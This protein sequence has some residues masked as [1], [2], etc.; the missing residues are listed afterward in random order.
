MPKKYRS[1]TWSIVF[2]L[3]ALIWAL[4]FLATI[5]GADHLKALYRARASAVLTDRNGEIVDIRLNSAGNYALRL[6]RLPAATAR[7]IIRKEDRWFYYH[8]GINPLSLV[9]AAWRLV[10]GGGYPSSSTITQQTA[11]LLLGQERERSIGNKLKEAWYAL[12]LEAHAGKDSILVMYANTAFFGNQAEGL[13]TAARLYCGRDL[14]ELTGAQ[15]VRL[16]AALGN[17]AGDNPFRENNIARSEAL[18]RRLG[19]ATD[20]GEYPAISEEAAVNDFTAYRQNEAAFEMGDLRSASPGGSRLTIDSGLT[21][22]IRQIAGDSLANMY[23]SGARNAAVAVIATPRGK[24]GNELLALV[25]SPD[26]SVDARG[27]KINMALRPRAI[28][29][30]IKPFIYARA[31]TLGLR[32]YTLVEDREYKY[33]I[34]TGYAFYPKNYDYEYRG[35]VNLHYALANSL[36]VPTVKVL[37][38]ITPPDFYSL[39]ENDLRFRPVQDLANYQLGIALGELEMDLLTL[40]HYFTIFPN[41]GILQPLQA[42]SGKGAYF[43]AGADFQAEKK[44]FEP[45]YARLANRIIADRQTGSE[46]FGLKSALNLPFRDYAVKTGTSREFH[47]SWTLGYTPDFTVG[48]WVGNAEDE[49]MDEVSGAA[50][51]GEIWS[52]VMDLLYNSPYNRGSEFDFSG[53]KDF[54]EG[55]SIEYGLPG[56]DY[57]RQKNLLT[58]DQLILSPHNGDEFLYADSM[59]LALKSAAAAEWSVNG[60]PLGSGAAE[61]YSPPAPGTYRIRAS[62]DGREEEITVYVNREE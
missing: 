37:E 42:D 52:Q 38:Y 33:T 20:R 16:L 32:P 14:R 25:G 12:A 10:A 1:K 44:I 5:P 61:F 35:T 8:P 47:D 17:P 39:L 62:A 13:Q 26:P 18:A 50:G 56:D 23:K 30:T 34:G 49:P 4:F 46:E 24:G 31:F 21:A 9:R 6:D 55:D 22:K 58:T 3:A 11:K 53:L 27:Y 19:S 2:A 36:N 43:E 48:V 15:T 54:S 59:S 57:E 45:A 40:T 51:A 41:D 7:M 29:S 60:E 28:G